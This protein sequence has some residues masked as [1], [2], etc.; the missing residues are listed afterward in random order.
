MNLEGR[1][2]ITATPLVAQT[3]QGLSTELGA[4][5]SAGVTLTRGSERAQIRPQQDIVWTK[6]IIADSANTAYL[7]AQRE[8]GRYYYNPVSVIRIS[9]PSSDQAITNY[10][11]TELLGERALSQLVSNGALGGI[12]ACSI[13]GKR[14]IVRIVS[15]P[16][17]DGVCVNRVA[18]Q[19]YTYY[20]DSNRLELIR[21]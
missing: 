10:S 2:P 9:L 15:K 3:D 8:F 20:V 16:P 14:L 7:L 1:A 19:S 18:Q 11:I 5:A 6:M 21:P 12:D 4:D 13:D 17:T